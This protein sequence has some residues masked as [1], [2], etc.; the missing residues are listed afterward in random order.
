MSSS[1]WP[2]PT[3][4]KPDSTNFKSAGPSTKSAGPVTKLAS[5]PRDSSNARWT[6]G[7]IKVLAELH[8]AG[9][10]PKQIAAALDG[11][12]TKAVTNQLADARTHNT[13]TGARINNAIALARVAKGGGDSRVRAA[14]PKAPTKAA[15]KIPT[16]SIPSNGSTP[17]NHRDRWTDAADRQL[18]IGFARGMLPSELAALCGRTKSSV[19]G[20]L[21]VLSVL[22]FDNVA[23]EFKTIPRVWLKVAASK[24]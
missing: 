24:A 18:L 8:V 9:K 15:P 21:H 2:F 10:T 13:P 6:D 1:K 4:V 19:A 5:V 7:E 14:S 20:R 11:R 23:M 3:G 22:T 16:K 17:T 12:S